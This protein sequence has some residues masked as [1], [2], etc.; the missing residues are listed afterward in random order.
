MKKIIFTSLISSFVLVQ[1]GCE[2]VRA[3][4]EARADPYVASQVMLTDNSLRKE[5]AVGQPVVSRDDAGN[6]LL[7]QVPIRSAVNRRLYIQY[8]VKFFDKTGREISSSGPFTKTL[9]PNVP[10]TIQ[11]NSLSGNAAD[12]QFNIRYAR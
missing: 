3:P 9:D 5:T 1:V 6:L 10:E 7:V 12:F 4:I 11:A 2:Q 8:T